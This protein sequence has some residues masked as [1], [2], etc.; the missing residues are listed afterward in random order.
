MGGSKE[1]PF[2]LPSS[3]VLSSWVF[4]ALDSA[5]PALEWVADSVQNVNP[6]SG[7]MQCLSVAP[8]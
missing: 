2:F 5:D 8:S 3:T 6:L 7:A 1:A 4:S